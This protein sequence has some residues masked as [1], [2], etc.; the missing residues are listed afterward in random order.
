MSEYRWIYGYTVMECLAV[1]HFKSDFLSTF[2]HHGDLDNGLTWSSLF[3]DY[4]E[5]LRSLWYGGTQPNSPYRDY[6]RVLIEPFGVRVLRKQTRT[7]THAHMHPVPSLWQLNFWITQFPDMI[8]L[9]YGSVK[10]IRCCWWWR[11]RLI[12][13]WVNQPRS[14]HCLTFI[15]LLL[16]SD[17]WTH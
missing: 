16:L 5:E 12:W 4:S 1:R 9:F 2:S 3:C 11:R 17:L 7:H 8:N 10:I 6:H 15:T 14:S 13:L